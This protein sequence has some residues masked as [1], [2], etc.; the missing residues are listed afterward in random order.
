MAR[1]LPEK[2]RGNFARGL[3]QLGSEAKSQ[4]TPTERILWARLRDSRF[5][6]YKFRQQYRVHLYRVDFYC[7]S[8]KLVV[9]LDGP[10]HDEQA[11]EDA[12][13]QADLESFGFR[14]LRFKNEEVAS[15]LDSVLA[16]IGQALNEVSA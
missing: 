6:G 13:R 7:A 14:V 2:P 11:K 5:G 10:V 9:E 12:V 4:P 16:K 3:R 15:S 1:D 8:A